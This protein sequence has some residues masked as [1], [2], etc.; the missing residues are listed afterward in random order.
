MGVFTRMQGAVLFLLGIVLG[1]SGIAFGDSAITGFS[2]FEGDALAT[3]QPS[4][5]TDNGTK[6][7]SSPHDWISKESIQVK[8]N[9]VILTVENPKWATYTN[10]NSMDPVID[11][12]S[13][14]IQIVPQSENDVH[15]GDIVAY[16]STFQEGI[17]AH[18]V[19]SISQDE[20]GWFAILKGDNNQKADPEKVR[21]SQIKRVV[22]A[23][24]Y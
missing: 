2:I 4:A 18:R 12:D 15:V 7:K 5:T 19:I 6:E 3:E 1:A 21:F 20:E 8:G 13:H 22:V 16:E 10:T 17:I 14:A 9:Q 23:I 11:S 24:I